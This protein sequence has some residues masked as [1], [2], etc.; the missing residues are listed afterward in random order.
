[1]P[2]SI[3]ADSPSCDPMRR[4]PMLRDLSSDPRPARGFTL[5]ELLICV[6]LVATL[7]ALAYPSFSDAIATARRTD[8]LMALMNVQM[9]QE[10]FRA[11]HR[12]YGEL[13]ELGAADISHAKHYAVAV[14]A[15]SAQGYSVRASALGSQQRD[16]LCRHLQLT[17]DGAQV[18]YQSGETD[19]TDNAAP[20]N[21]RCWRL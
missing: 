14:V 3:A 2:T 5:I 8:A 1:M 15:H 7:S 20:V 12:S 9:L 17:V 18:I 16:L 11:D 4:H 13:D 6:G 21:R 19:A 10:R